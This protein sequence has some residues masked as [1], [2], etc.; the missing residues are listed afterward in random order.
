[1]RIKFIIYWIICNFIITTVSAQ[2]YD[3]AEALYRKGLRCYNENNFEDAFRYFFQA[4]GLGNVKSAYYLGEYYLRQNKYP[5]ALRYYLRAADK[6]D[7][8]AYL[9]LGYCYEN[10]L[11]VKRNIREACK[12][13]LFAAEQG[14]VEAQ[15]RLAYC[16]LA[17]LDNENAIKWLKAAAESNHPEALFKLGQCYERGLTGVVNQA[18][19]IRL[20]CL[21]ADS[22]N[23]DAQLKVGSYYKTSNP[24]ESIR[25]YIMAAEKNNRTAFYALYELCRNGYYIPQGKIKDRLREPFNKI[26]EQHKQEN[27]ELKNYFDDMFKQLMKFKHN[28]DFII[29]GFGVASPYAEWLTSMEAKREFVMNNSAVDPELIEVAISITDLGYEYVAS[30]GRETE[31]SSYTTQKVHDLL[32]NYKWRKIN[33]I[34]KELNK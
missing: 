17:T 3:R 29:Y 22:G 32:K 2:D 8:Q 11:G 16:Y 4:E 31:H 14:L 34:C 25:Y 33:E 10:A 21:A 19:A 26:D 9:R 18:E 20:Y 5:E 1:M 24:T 15:Y 23:L 6:G 28:R 30:Y 12:K 7:A 27:M 13:Y